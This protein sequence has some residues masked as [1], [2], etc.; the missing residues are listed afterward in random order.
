VIAPTSP[1]QPVSG[2]LGACKV[3]VKNFTS[4]FK[5]SFWKESLMYLSK[6]SASEFPSSKAK[7]TVLE[8]SRLN[9]LIVTWRFHKSP[10]LEQVL[11]RPAEQ[12]S[13]P[14]SDGG[15]PQVEIIRS[16]SSNPLQITSDS[17]LKSFRPLRPVPLFRPARKV[18]HVS[19]KLPKTCIT[20]SG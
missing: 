6:K 20:Y 10:S 14:F 9:R 5:K 19:P 7:Q 16:Q 4:K 12:T 8:A 13:A 17:N 15:W 18:P 2:Y 1:P 11:N 3:V